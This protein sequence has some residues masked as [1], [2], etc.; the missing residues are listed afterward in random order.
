MSRP[1]R[2]RARG[3]EQDPAGSNL[4]RTLERAF[5]TSSPPGVLAAWLFGS[6]AEGRAHRESDVDV[7]VLLDERTYPTA[8]ERSEAR[9]L[10]SAWLVGALSFNDVDVVVLNGAP[11]LLGRKAVSDGVPVHVSDAERTRVWARDVQLRAADLAPFLAR[12]R[13]TLLE[14]LAR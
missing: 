1:S 7:A 6:Q 9:V 3:A 10:I 14:A 5:S 13:V 12:H 8:A 11:P 4:R 2:P